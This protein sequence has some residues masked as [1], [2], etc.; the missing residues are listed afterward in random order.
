[1][2]TNTIHTHTLPTI[3]LG[4][5]LAAGAGC[6]HS[7]ARPLPGGP[8][9]AESVDVGYGKQAKRAVTG[10]V[11]SLSAEEIRD[12]RVAR[13]E[14]LLQGRVAGVQVI[15]VPGGG[16]SVRVRGTSSILGSR[17][18]LFV[19]DGVPLMSASGGAPW[20]IDPRDVERIEV[21]KDAGATAIYGSRGANGVILITTRRAPPPRR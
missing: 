21:L 3:V 4:I 16:F 20:G 8:A 2:L 15:R 10:A 18:P 6:R 1:M 13:V 5:V 7:P 17:E 19:V 11:R 9:P 14:E 12:A